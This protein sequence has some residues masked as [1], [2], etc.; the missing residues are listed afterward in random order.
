M[1]DCGCVDGYLLGSLNR[2]Q[3]QRI[4]YCVTLVSHLCSSPSGYQREPQRLGHANAAIGGGCGFSCICRLQ[5][6]KVQCLWNGRVQGCYTPLEQRAEDYNYAWKFL[7]GLTTAKLPKR[8]PVAYTLSRGNLAFLTVLTADILRIICVRAFWEKNEMSVK[9]QALS[10]F[11]PL[12]LA[13]W[14]LWNVKCSL[15]TQGAGLVTKGKWGSM[16]Q[17]HEEIKRETNIWLFGSNI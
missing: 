14:P 6:Q 15:F 4:Q 2:C 5:I 3:S 16:R 11:S 1:H 13:S 9:R 12:S 10:I 17:D 7:A 8:L